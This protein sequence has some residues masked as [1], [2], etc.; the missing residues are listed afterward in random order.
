MLGGELAAGAG[1][2]P[3]DERYGELAARHVQQ[4]GGVVEDLV[5]REQAEVHR[6]DL[7]DRPHPAQGGADP[8]ADERR[9]RQRGVPDPFGPELL[10]QALA[11]REAAAV[12]ADVLAHQE[13]ALVAGERLA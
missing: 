13:H 12:A 6:H 7:D 8:G 5:E 3:H 2:D 11:H 1:R 9:L 4:G 10:E